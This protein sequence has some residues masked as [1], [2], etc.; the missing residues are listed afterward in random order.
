M[1]QIKISEAVRDGKILVSD[2]A[3]GTFLQQQGLK[4]GECPELWCVE[5][6]DDVLFVAQKYVESGADMIQANSF[7]GNR[8]KLEHYGLADRTTEI[9]KAAAAISRKAAG[10]NG[11]V[12]A[13]MGP[14]GKM[15]V[16]GDVTEDDLQQ[17]FAEQAAALAE[18]GTDAVCI[19]TMSALD[20]ACAAIRGAEQVAPQVEKISTFTFEKTV[21]GDF[22]T[23]MGVSP[24][25]AAEAAIQAGADIIGSNCGNGFAGMIEITKL[26]RSVD[27]DIP[28]LIHANAGL[29][30]NVDGKDVFPES[31]QEMADQ[32]EELMAAG[33]NI[34]GGCCGTTPEHI[35][36]LKE[37]IEKATGS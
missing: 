7:G 11:W 37:R 32:V 15:T 2:G 25:Q 26:L 10:D 34:I 4:P 9:N 31:P 20:E 36:A 19:E 28:I 23:M 3:W 16:M 8:Y 33:A 18:G 14:T 29:P 17:A 30:K 21:N 5:R 27:A 6:P 24:E 13:S 12:I 22:R 35:K 1:P